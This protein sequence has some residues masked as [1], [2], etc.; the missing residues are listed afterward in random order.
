MAQLRKGRTTG[1][2]AALAAK[3]ATLALVEARFPEEVLSLL[4]NGAEP[5]FL[6]A[7]AEMPVAGHD[8]GVLATD[9]FAS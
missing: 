2:C 5:R 8:G 1:C 4:P 3:A 7:D 6:P 9:G